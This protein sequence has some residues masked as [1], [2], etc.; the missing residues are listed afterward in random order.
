MAPIAV[1]SGHS[2]YQETH[3][4]PT[5]HRLLGNR[6]PNLFKIVTQDERIIDAK[7]FVEKTTGMDAIAYKR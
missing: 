5:K 6:V 4:K 7:F 2:K 1:K 3:Q